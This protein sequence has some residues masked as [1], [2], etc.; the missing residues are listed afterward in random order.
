M[1]IIEEVE[2]KGIRFIQLQ[3]MDI[4]GTLKAVMAP[5]RRLPDALDDGIHFDGSSVVGY[6]TIDESDMILKPDPATFQVLPWTHP[7][8]ALNGQTVGQPTAG[9]I[10]NVNSHDGNP[11]EGDPRYILRKQME[12]ARERGYIF[13]T[14]PELEF[15]LFQM[16]DGQPSAKIGDYGGYFELLTDKN[17]QVI[18]ELVYYLNLMGFDVEAYHHEVAPSQ[19]EVD[20]GYTDALTSADR[21]LMTKYVI[22]TLAARH[23]L[24]ATFMPKPL[25]GVCGSGMHI[26]QS[27]F[28][29]NGTNAFH[30]P[31]GRWEL[32]DTAL[33]YLSGLL[34]H[35][36]E[37]C[38]ILASWVNS[39][40]RLVEGYE[41][42][43]YITWAN[44]NRSALLRIPAG[45]GKSTRI[46]QRNPDPA[47]NPY[48]QFAVMLASGMNGI[49]CN[50]R[51][52]E[53][54]EEE[55][56]KEKEVPRL[57]IPEPVE[58]N[59]F[60]LTLEERTKLGI[61]ALPSNLGEAVYYLEKS[62]FMWET[63]GA[64]LMNHF[65]RV[66]KK[67]YDDYRT[68]VTGW[69]LEKLLPIL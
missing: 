37:N 43:V 47:G 54:V 14:G 36:R 38:A 57:I 46:E 41:A 39:Y 59:I 68:Q 51:P 50:L 34:S 23:S 56:E 29:T 31:D 65:L 21:V 12:K 55:L 61:K 33:S 17:E 5:A 18:T 19:Y 10:C 45:R 40:K 20:P 66:K 53:P 8:T 16:I 15:F 44:M 3:F 9:L 52:P 25:F 64:T 32:S 4:L 1:D 22:R 49:E 30:D 11:F 60:K 63:L 13:N 7:D 24:Y 27:L 42:P 62:E 26:N 48:L 35:A 69:E 2:K 28:S 6:A 67:E 58:K